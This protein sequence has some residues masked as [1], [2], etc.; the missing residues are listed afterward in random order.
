[1][2]LATAPFLQSD[3]RQSWQPN[4]VLGL[5]QLPPLLD[6]L[7]MFFESYARYFL[8]EITSFEAFLPASKYAEH[9][10]CLVFILSDLYPCST[11]GFNT[12]WLKGIANVLS[13][14]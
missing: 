13:C 6:L 3:I 9:A 12:I 14:K 5:F 2:F 4:R 11:K 7:T 10:T 8:R 1:M